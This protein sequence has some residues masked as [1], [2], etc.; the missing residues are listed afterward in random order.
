MNCWHILAKRNEKNHNKNDREKT[1]PLLLKQGAR[2]TNGKI[3]IYSK[4]KSD[5]EICFACVKELLILSQ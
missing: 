5:E 1:K 3:S 4:T 2:Q